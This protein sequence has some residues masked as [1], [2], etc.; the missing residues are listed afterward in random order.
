[1]KS[2]AIAPELRDA[3]ATVEAIDQVIRELQQP[4]VLMG[5]H[6]RLVERLELVRAELVICRAIINGLHG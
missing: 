4:F 3:L 6:R 5:N 1:M 2:R